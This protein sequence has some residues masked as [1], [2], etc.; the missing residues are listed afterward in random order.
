MDT[1]CDTCRGTGR[2][3]RGYSRWER[4]PDCDTADIPLREYKRAAA[5]NAL[6]SCWGAFEKGETGEFNFSLAVKR[7]LSVGYSLDE[8]ARRRKIPMDALRKA[9]GGQGILSAE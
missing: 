2:I 5:M 6:A 3:Y 7:C 4:C 8:I 1:V 9:A